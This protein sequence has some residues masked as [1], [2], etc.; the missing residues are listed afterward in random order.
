MYKRGTVKAG[1]RLSPVLHVDSFL[2]T[3]VTSCDL[4]RN[5]GTRHL[6]PTEQEQSVGLGTCSLWKGARRSSM[7]MS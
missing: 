5:L 2:I 4:Q 3:W 7:A 6:S 1:E